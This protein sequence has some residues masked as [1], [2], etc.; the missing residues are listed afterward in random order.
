VRR[1]LVAVAD[2][3]PLFR[4][5]VRNLIQR[6]SDLDVI[7]V[8]SAR[9]LHALAPDIALVDFDLPLGGGI[10]AVAELVGACSARAIVW[11]LAPTQETVLAAIQAGATGYLDK[12][13]SPEG[14]IRSLRGL[15]NGEAPISRGLT[16]MM[17]DALHGL[18]RRDRV[19]ERAA[20]LSLRE[21][22]VLDLVA[23]GSRNR[24]IAAALAISEFTVKRHVQNILEKLELPSRQAA[25][26]FHAEAMAS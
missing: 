13:V 23:I 4:A 25:A 17:I 11:S 18:E 9:E 3:L 15:V 2:S 16:T 1:P 5:G 10:A 26:V 7:E 14:L 24:E 12:R 21:R 6:E 22:Q 8:A 19:R 20:L